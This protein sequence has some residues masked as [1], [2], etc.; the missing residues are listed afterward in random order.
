MNYKW[1]ITSSEKDVT[2]TYESSDT[3]IATVNK[4]GEIKSKKKRGNTTITVTA[5]NGKKGTCIVRVY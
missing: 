5:S 3:S 4:N 2:F 1:K